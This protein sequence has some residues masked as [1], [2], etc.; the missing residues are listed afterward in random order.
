[1]RNPLNRKQVIR[2]NHYDKDIIIE[3]ASS[4][5]KEFKDLPKVSQL[6]QNSWNMSPYTREEVYK[7]VVTDVLR[8][9]GRMERYRGSLSPNKYHEHR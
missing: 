9:I 5:K 4:E 3:N 1:M 2:F 8:L 7:D 6:S